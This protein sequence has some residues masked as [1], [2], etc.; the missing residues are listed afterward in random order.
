MHQAD[1][2][3]FAG[4]SVVGLLDRGRATATYVVRP[5]DS[6][7]LC[8]LK[9]HDPN[10]LGAASMS[11]MSFVTGSYQ[12]ISFD[13][14][15]PKPLV[16]EAA[17]VHTDATACHGLHDAIV[18]V[19]RVGVEPARGAPWF[20]YPFMHGRSVGRAIYETGPFAADQVFAVAKALMEAI[21]ELNSRQI[22]HAGISPRTV[23]LTTSPAQPV[24]L[25]DT[26]SWRVRQRSAGHRQYWRGRKMLGLEQSL[27][28]R[29][30]TPP[31]TQLPP[32]PDAPMY[33]DAE[34]GRDL[35]E[36]AAPWELRSDIASVA[37]LVVFLVTGVAGT[38][39][40]PNS[41][42]SLT[43]QDS[44]PA[45]Y[46]IAVRQSLTEWFIRYASKRYGQTVDPLGAL[47]ELETILT[48]VR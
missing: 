47:A 41:H 32:L 5:P 3:E 25:L 36:E 48:D 21:S 20:L 7:E 27:A 30:A 45:H 16:F 18:P 22:Y 31:P 39:E 10:C 17:E 35:W 26:A 19:V 2:V 11:G 29:A 6:G 13:A 34:P 14:G 28:I 12:G 42:Y 33:Q 46:T 43:W 4:F 15:S 44:L 40:N 38:P 37:F 23:L 24:V 8:V 9:V 1:S